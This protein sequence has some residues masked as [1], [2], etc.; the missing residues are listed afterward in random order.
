LA[1]MARIGLLGGS[2]N[3]AHAAHRHISLVA[4]QQLQLD[5]VWWLVSPQNPLKS[6]ESMAALDSRVA[7]A[8]REARHPRIRVTALETVLGTRY[9]VDT[10]IALKRRYP[11]HRFI[12]LAGDDIVAELHRWRRWR[13]FLREIPL[14]VAP[15]PGVTLI[16]AP[17]LSWAGWSPIL[18]SR[19]TDAPLPAIIRL[20]AGLRPES[21]TALRRH[22]PDWANTTR[23][24]V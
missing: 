19:W 18:P 16:G 23:M 13:Q 14:A 2:F 8:Q 1:L 22:D 15:R 17:A 11:Q 4:M 6:P 3:P 20:H 7:R 5:A 10:V 12:W 9:A 21:A 24:H